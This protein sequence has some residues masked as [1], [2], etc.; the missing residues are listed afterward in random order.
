V[1]RR[2]A[3]AEAE[4]PQAD[5]LI[6]YDDGVAAKRPVGDAGC[7]QPQHGQQ[8][9]I[10]GAVSEADAVGLRQGRA[11]GHPAH[12]RRITAGPELAGGEHVGHE[13]ASPPGHQGEVGL[14]LNLLQ[15]VQDQGGA[16]IPVHAEPPQFRQHPGV[17]C[18]PAV[19]R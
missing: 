11:I 3:G 12:Q 18:V 15:A 10:Q 16:R 6:G 5:A 19:D 7:S 9:L 4:A 2:L 13:H 14:V 8:D 1:S 17:G